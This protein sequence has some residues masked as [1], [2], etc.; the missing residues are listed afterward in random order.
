MEAYKVWAT[1]NI[2]GNAH[3]KMEQFLALVKKTTLEV[4]KLLKTLDKFSM[5]F[6]D[7]SRIFNTI[8]PE[9]KIYNINIQQS[10][11]VMNSAT[12]AANRYAVAINRVN[13]NIRSGG[14]GGR[15]PGSRSGSFAHGAAAGLGARHLGG[16]GAAAGGY[17]VAH[18]IGS[19][20]RSGSE[21]QK[22]LALLRG[23][24]IPGLDDKA[25]QSFLN[26]TR[27]KGASRLDLLEALADAAVITKGSREAIGVAPE[28]V[29]MKLVGSGLGKEGF[30][31]T[32]KQLQAAIKTSEIVSGSRDPGKLNEYLGMMMKTWISTQGRVEPTQYQSI[33]RSSR[34]YTAGMDPKFFFYMLE[35]LIQEFGTRTGPMLAQFYQHM[36]VGRVTTQA[37]Q[38][39]G[40]I[41]LV[42]P[43][44]VQLNKMGMIKGI[45][46]GGI[47]GMD[48]AGKNIFEW[49]DKFLLPALQKGGYKSQDQQLGVLGKIFTNTDL[50]LILTYL[51]QREKFVASAKVNE[52][53][54]SLDK[55][56]KQLGEMHSG[57]MQQFVSSFTEFAISLD[58]ITGPL[59]DASLL[60]LSRFFNVLS[61]GINWL[62]SKTEGTSSQSLS[63]MLSSGGANQSFLSSAN[64]APPSQARAGGGSAGVFLLN[65]EKIGD[66]IFGRG[67][68]NFNTFV[69][70]GTTSVN[71]YSSPFST[72][73]N[74]FGSQGQ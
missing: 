51:Q 66:Y 26:G 2:R 55:M 10:T 63:Q 39:L 31:M 36:R 19:A 44:A 54:S 35:P 48:V 58:K 52:N 43:E 41:G 70:H 38:I 68:N 3:K 13:N 6:N 5:H 65:G 69:Q 57:K 7:L 24:N 25:I 28:L 49:I 22:E 61:S 23:Q 74:S 71:S 56:L 34:G 73:F 4:N 17:A 20:F 30:R 16:L 8:N 11:N 9:I 60:A 37:A 59:V 27:I 33:V 12:F 47:K 15:G 21:Y 29:K 46:P 72:A 1:L 62:A 14:G 45:S 40:Q 42:N 50:T 32:P 64:V 53:T 67:S 18:T